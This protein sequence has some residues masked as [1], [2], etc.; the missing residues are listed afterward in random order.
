MGDGKKS[1]R[2]SLKDLK[3][4]QKSLHSPKLPSEGVQSVK[5]QDEDRK[6]NEVRVSKQSK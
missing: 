2:E 1:V 4:S 6:S 3:Q 5:K